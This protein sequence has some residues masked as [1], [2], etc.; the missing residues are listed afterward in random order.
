MGSSHAHHFPARRMRRLKRCPD[1]S[2][3]PAWDNAGLLCKL[4]SLGW[5]DLNCHKI[6]PLFSNLSFL[7]PSQRLIHMVQH[8]ADW[9]APFPRRQHYP[10]PPLKYF[11][12]LL[13]PPPS[14]SPPSSS[15]P[16]P[17][18]PPYVHEG[19][20]QSLPSTQMTAIHNWEKISP[21]TDNFKR[22]TA[23]MVNWH[24]SAD[25]FKIS[26]RNVSIY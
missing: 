14:S 25:F 10:P 21:K 26:S 11:Y 22:N 5:R 4:Y 7:I 9:V 19:K 2:A 6:L 18:S 15:S 8:V 1:G 12:T 13:P 16:P 17:S 20:R 3:S 24:E 23:S